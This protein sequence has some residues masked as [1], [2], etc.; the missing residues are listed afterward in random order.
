MRYHEKLKHITLSACAVWVFSHI[1]DSAAVTFLWHYGKEGK[2]NELGHH[3]I[4]HI[5][6]IRWKQGYV[7]KHNTLYQLN[8]LMYTHLRWFFLLLKSDVYWCNPLFHNTT[9]FR[10][11]NQIKPA[12]LIM[13]TCSLF[14]GRHMLRSAG[15][16]WT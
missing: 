16:T 3:R 11:V 14:R 1:K 7:F 12:V 6:E 4:V 5:E 8:A 9:D 10:F 15:S 2:S 13:N